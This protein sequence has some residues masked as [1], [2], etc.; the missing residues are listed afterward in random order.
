MSDPVEQLKKATVAELS[1]AVDQITGKQFVLSHR[2]RLIAGARMFG[3]AV[4]IMVS[5]TA[6]R[7]PHTASDEAIKAAPAGSVVIAGIED[8]MDAAVWGAAAY[9]FAADAGLAGFVTDGSIREAE[10][11]AAPLAIFAAGRSPASGF[12]RLKMMAANI[13]ITCGGVVVQPGDYIAGDADGVI[14]LPQDRLSEIADAL[15]TS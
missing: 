1:D 14:V 3:P 15:E 6:E 9:G 13:E 10:R 7:A 4:T 12:G 2:V 8:D 11:A 5:E